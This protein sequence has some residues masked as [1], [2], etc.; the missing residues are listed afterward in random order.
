MIADCTL[1]GDSIAYGTSYFMKECQLAYIKSGSNTTTITKNF[2]TDYK[3]NVIISAG[4][5]DYLP[6]LQLYESLR[7]KYSTSNIIWI[8]PAKRFQKSRILIQEVAEKYKDITIELEEVGID[9]VHPTFN[10]YKKTA[11]KIKSYL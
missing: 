5:N 2:I 8:L 1:T 3:K 6:N 10:G 9:G 11:T 7:Q 4:S